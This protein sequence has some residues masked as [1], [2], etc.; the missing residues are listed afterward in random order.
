MIDSVILPNVDV[1][2]WTTEDLNNVE[3]IVDGGD[4]D[5]PPLKRPITSSTDESNSGHVEH[6]W[7]FLRI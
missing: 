2:F 6:P 7:H 3:L 1:H 5:N 4:V